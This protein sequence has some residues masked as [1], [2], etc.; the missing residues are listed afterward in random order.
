MPVS[1]LAN[2]REQQGVFCFD[3]VVAKDGNQ[4]VSWRSKGSCLELWAENLGSESV[5]FSF[6]DGTSWKT[7]VAGGVDVY[8]HKMIGF[9][10]RRKS[11]GSGSSI[12]NCMGLTANPNPKPALAVGQYDDGKVR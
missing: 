12:I 7:L 8:R 3:L 9:H 1:T 2:M 4:Y 5:E 10:F 11:G 6:D